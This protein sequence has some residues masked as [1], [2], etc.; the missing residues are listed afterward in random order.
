[1]FHKVIPLLLTRVKSFPDLQHANPPP[2][3]RQAGAATVTIT[4]MKKSWES[5]PVTGGFAA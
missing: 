2:D 4:I 1:M 5:P 3:F